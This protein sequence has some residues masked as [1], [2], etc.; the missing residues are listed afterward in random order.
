GNIC[1]AD[2]FLCNNSLCKLHFWVC[3]GEDDCGDN[4]DEVAEMCVKFPC[5]PTRPY[6]CRNNRVCLR[7]E[8]ICNEVDDCGDNSDED[9]CD[10]ITYKARPCKK[11][12]FACSDKKCIPME[13]QCDWFDDCGDGSDEQDCKISE[14][15]SQDLFS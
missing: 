1:R 4:S 10:K 12:E 2:E 14:L 8:Q 7:P 13:L 11:D 5:P 6:R 15:G 3:D 9:H